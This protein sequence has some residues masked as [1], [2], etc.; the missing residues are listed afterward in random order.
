[1]ERLSERVAIV[2]G[3]AGGILAAAARALAAE[4]ASAVVAD[5]RDTEGTD[6]AAELGTPARYPHLDFS[7]EDDWQRAL[8]ETERALG[9]VSVLV[10]IAGIIG[11]RSRPWNS[12]PTGSGSAPSTPAPYAP[13]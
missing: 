1:M 4:G 5:I 2:T 7:G 8:A 6:L 11:C 13:G 9:P 3:G 10:N 12:H